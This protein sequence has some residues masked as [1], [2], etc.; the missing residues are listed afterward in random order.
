MRAC[1]YLCVKKSFCFCWWERSIRFSI[2]KHYFGFNMFC[3][4]ANWYRFCAIFITFYFIWKFCVKSEWN[5]LSLH[6]SRKWHCFVRLLKFAS[7][8]VFFRN[9][10]FWRIIN[11]AKYTASVWIEHSNESQM[12]VCGVLNMIWGSYLEK[13]RY[14]FRDLSEKNDFPNKMF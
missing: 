2:Q 1:M 14:F 8:L 3:C 4:H 5:Y 11:Y 13:P 6:W 10:T 9:F 12:K 7:V